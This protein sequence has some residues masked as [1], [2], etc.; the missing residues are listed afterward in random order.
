MT[1]S[2]TIT[3]VEEKAGYSKISYLYVTATDGTAT[4][5]T[6]GDYT[7]RIL[8]V[9]SDP[10]ATAPTEGWDF[11][12]QN[13]DNY[14]LIKGAGTDRSASIT[15]YLQGETDGLGCAVREKLTLE[16]ENGGNTKG[17]TVVVY[18]VK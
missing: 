17:G 5:E 2:V 9:I 14:D 3:E 6:L 1:E 16:V 4:G 10:G 18:I 13:E 7:G 11:Q 8:Y 12:I 15:E